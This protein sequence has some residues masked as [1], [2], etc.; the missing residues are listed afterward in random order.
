MNGN[1]L[2]KPPS[3]ISASPAHGFAP[4][5]W[6]NCAGVPK[7]TALQRY[8][9]TSIDTA[10]QVSETAEVMQEWL[11]SKSAKT[12]RAYRESLELFLTF[13]HGYSAEPFHLASIKLR[14]LQAWQTELT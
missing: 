1:R 8:L 2:R 9:T 3:A 14:M 12:Q 13:A 4:L 6:K 10:T 7:M 5:Y 11:Y